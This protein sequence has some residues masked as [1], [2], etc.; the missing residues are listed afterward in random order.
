MFKPEAGKDTLTNNK[1]DT[2]WKRDHG[3]QI[4]YVGFAG[5]VYA[6]RIVLIYFR[7]IVIILI[8]SITTL[9]Q[10]CLILQI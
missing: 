2:S 6:P 8:I 10:L 3:A 9:I 1:G 7:D 4:K 5:N